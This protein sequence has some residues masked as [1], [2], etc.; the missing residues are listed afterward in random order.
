MRAVG[1]GFGL[2]WGL[3][4]M[5]AGCASHPSFEAYYRTAALHR[6]SRVK[7]AAQPRS[8]KPN[9]V[10]PFRGWPYRFTR[11]QRQRLRRAGCQFNA[12]DEF[13]SRR[14]HA[15]GYTAAE[16]VRAFED[17]RQHAGGERSQLVA[18]A[19]FRTAGFD[20]RRYGEYHRSSGGLTAYYNRRF[21]NSRAPF[22]A[23]LVLTALG[24]ATAII[25]GGFLIAGEVNVRRC[26]RDLRND[27]E[28]ETT[29]C[30]DLAYGLGVLIVG[31][32]AGLGGLVGLAGG[33][34]S[35]ATWNR[36]HRHLDKPLLDTADAETLRDFQRWRRLVDGKSPGATLSLAPMRTRGGGGMV[37]RLR[38]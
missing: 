31:S 38:F 32:I 27:P 37:M 26:E 7:H 1:I 23:G 14:L 11:V 35:L 33:I 6:A 3:V 12:Q 19:A 18:I 13:W 4:S 22:V 24:F 36:P 9:S 20:L 25:A 8:L 2:V 29:E 21:A 30:R 17:V 16:F 5:T 10:G 28:D 34:I 15:L